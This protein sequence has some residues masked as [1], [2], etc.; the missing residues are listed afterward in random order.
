MRPATVFERHGQY[1]NDVDA[2]WLD[3]IAP[4]VRIAGGERGRPGWVD[5]RRVIYDHELMMVGEGGEV[6]FDLMDSVGTV[7]TYHCHGPAFIVIPPGIWHTCRGIVCEGIPRVWVHFDWVPVPRSPQTPVLTYHPASPRADLFRAAPSF[8][9]KGIV[10]GPIPSVAPAFDIHTRLTERYNH[11]TPRVRATSR[12]LLLELLLYLLS[13][14]THS[15]GPSAAAPTQ[16]VRTREALDR[17]AQR[18]F[19]QAEGVKPYLT[20]LGK[21]YDHQA[22]LFH[23]TYGVTPLQYVNAQRMERARGLLRDTDE[24]VGRIARRLGFRDVVY[25]NRL[26]RKVVG[27]TPGAYRTTARGRT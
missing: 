19:A 25:F 3:R 7:R 4:Q 11:G 26:F 8:V 2:R 12:A 20:A 10:T 15:P 23:A 9:P 6:A 17:L 13:P 1:K 24:P 14:E 22:R 27:V 16:A 21:S 18:P 5:P